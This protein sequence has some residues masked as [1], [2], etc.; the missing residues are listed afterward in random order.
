MLARGVDIFDPMSTSKTKARPHGANGSENATGATFELGN[1]LR[2]PKRWRWHYTTLLRLRERLVEER[3]AALGVASQP[4]DQGGVDFADCAT[5]EFDRALSVSQLS[6]EQDTL[7][8][9]EAALR[10]IASGT[11]GI[12][13]RTG[14]RIPAARLKAIPWTCYGLAEATRLEKRGVT[15]RQHLGEVRSIRKE[16]AE[17]LAEDRPSV[18]QTESVWQLG[19]I[20]K[21]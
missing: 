1:G 18:E 12:C 14:K 16:T 13:E 3:E 2:I 8:E 6:E 7:Y 11:Y 15:L 9:I 17:A 10:R 5:D 21:T 4:I 19:D 20:M